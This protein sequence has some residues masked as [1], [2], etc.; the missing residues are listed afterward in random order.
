MDIIGFLDAYGISY[1]T[2]GPKTTRGWAQIEI[3]PF[4]YGSNFYMGLNLQGGFGHCWMCGASGSME[5]LIRKILNVSR[6][7]AQK[8]AK[9]FGMAFN[10]V[11]EEPF[12]SAQR[13]EIAGMG[14][15]RP[16]H[17]RYLIERQFSPNQIA[18]RYRLG[19]C[20]T[21]GRFPYRLVIPVYENGTLVNATARDVTGEQQE[22][23]MSLHN[24]EAVVPIK[25]TVYNLDAVN[26]ENI[27][28]VEGPFDVWRI[29][30]ATV[31]LFGT[32]FKMA[33]VVKILAK[34][35]K[36]AYV[37]FDNEETAQKS[38]EALTACLAPFVPH[39]QILEIDVKDPAL[40]SEQEAMEIRNELQL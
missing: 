14:E 12:E 3:C 39:V 27:L 18:R 21:T 8:V 36:N 28:I 7:Q 19:G 5:Y 35:P 10:D 4:C 6:T 9:Q 16:L 11:E 26:K 17:T 40:L 30:G 32:A 25:E 15:L 23:Y 20:Y 37:L 38:A 34:V 33:Q 22:R 1:R 29:G 31:C 2:T 24:D 13:V